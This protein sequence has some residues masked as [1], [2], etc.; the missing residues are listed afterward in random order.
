VSST[1]F[2]FF[3]F[4]VYTPFPRREP[5]AVRRSSMSIKSPYS[6]YAEWSVPIQIGIDI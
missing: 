5:Q 2:F 1:G 6:N 4:G 3:F